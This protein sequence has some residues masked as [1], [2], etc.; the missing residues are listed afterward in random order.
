MSYFDDIEDWCS[1][2]GYKTPEKRGK[3]G[4][5]DERRALSLLPSVPRN[6]TYALNAMDRCSMALPRTCTDI[7]NKL[8]DEFAKRHFSDYR[9]EQ[10]RRMEA[11][12]QRE[13][14][15]FNMRTR[16]V[17]YTRRYTLTETPMA[18]MPNRKAMV[19]ADGTKIWYYGGCRYVAKSRWS[20]YW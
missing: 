11:D 3:D 20:K 8:H 10:V 4:F 13:R 2:N 16:K 15:V 1:E 17:S 14:D 19:D 6:M 12:V 7:R 5:L 9:A 18:W